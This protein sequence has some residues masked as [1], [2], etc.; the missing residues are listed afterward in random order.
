M[1]L[2]SSDDFQPLPPSRW[3]PS[4]LAVSPEG[5][6]P[7]E[8]CPTRLRN[9]AA[10][11]EADKSFLAC[12][13][14]AG[15]ERPGRGRFRALS[16]R[17][18]VVNAVSTAYGLVRAVATPWAG[19]KVSRRPDLDSVGAVRAAVGAG[20]DVR[21][22]RNRVGHHR[23]LSSRFEPLDPDTRRAN[24]REAIPPR[25]RGLPGRARRPA[26]RPAPRTRMA[27]AR[28]ACLVAQACSEAQERL[29]SAFCVA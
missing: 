6:A 15:W 8:R 28:G 21:T 17:G 4:P 3:A 23:L 22:G 19:R 24:E 20:R 29:G 25:A 5:R 18:G 11:K 27:A 9:A 26:R 12:V 16:G 7:G 13:R 2:P 1:L 14:G 10:V